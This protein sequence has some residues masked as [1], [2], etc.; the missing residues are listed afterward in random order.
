[1]GVNE[2][3][4]TP[5]LLSLFSGGTGSYTKALVTNDPSQQLSKLLLRHSQQQ[6]DGEQ[7]K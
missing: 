1:M 3:V 7:A 6:S 4:L 5:A 2:V